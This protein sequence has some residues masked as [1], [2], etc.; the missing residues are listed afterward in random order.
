MR[1][2]LWGSSWRM[3]LR[4]EIA[5]AP[6]LP[7]AMRLPLMGLHPLSTL[8]AGLVLLPRDCTIIA[9]SPLPLA[10][11]RRCP[12]DD[13]ALPLCFDT[14]SPRSPSVPSPTPTLTLSQS[15]APPAPPPCPHP[16]PLWAPPP[17]AL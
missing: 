12:I 2:V 3:T 15:L 14:A 16:L 7:R 4:P 11:G 6:Q 17:P 10:N 5:V 13:R 9:A 1:A 8:T